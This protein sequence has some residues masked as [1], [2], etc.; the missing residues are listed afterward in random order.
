MVLAACFRMNERPIWSC[1]IQTSRS[2]DAACYCVQ[3]I[4]WPVLSI[5]I[6]NLG[7]RNV[8]AQYETILFAERSNRCCPL[9]N[10][11][12]DPIDRA[13]CSTIQAVPRRTSSIDRSCLT[14]RIIDRETVRRRAYHQKWGSLHPEVSDRRLDPRSNEFLKL[15]I[16]L[17]TARIR[18]LFDRTPLEDSFSNTLTK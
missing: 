10:V 16:D 15:T 3:D 17:L 2:F 12:H 9:D 13:V 8:P 4:Y 11:Q 5:F 7:I 14:D 6:C 18:R 1:S